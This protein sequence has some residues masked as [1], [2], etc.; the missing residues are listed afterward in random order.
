MRPTARLR[1][2]LIDVELSQGDRTAVRAAITL[3]DPEHHVPP[4]L[5]VN[6]VIPLMQ[7]DPPPG[8][9]PIGDG[10]PMADIV[11]LAHGCDI[12]PSL[13]TIRPRSTAGRR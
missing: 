9:E 6:P 8:L 1:V 2:S 5:S 11:H 10:H 4:L 12:R 3:G 7:P 13:T